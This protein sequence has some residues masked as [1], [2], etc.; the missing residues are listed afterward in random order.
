MWA[1]IQIM[2]V[3]ICASISVSNRGRDLSLWPVVM[4]V[5]RI[6]WSQTAAIILNFLVCGKPY[7]WW[8]PT[9]TYIHETRGG[10][11]YLWPLILITS[12]NHWGHWQGFIQWQNLG[13]G[14]ARQMSGHICSILRLGGFWDF[15]GNSMT[16]S[17][18]GWAMVF[19]D[20]PPP[21]DEILACL[22]LI[23]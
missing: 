5:R 1:D 6:S 16:L 19:G 22:Q 10:H 7:E 18:R 23:A 8:Q 9:A 13:D 4:I 20:V 17:G 15:S 3:Q 14:E 2:A 21:L 11:W 12:I